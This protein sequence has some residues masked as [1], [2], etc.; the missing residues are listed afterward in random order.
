MAVIQH[1]EVHQRESIG[2]ATAPRNFNR[3]EAYK[4]ANAIPRL[5]ASSCE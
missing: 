2:V 1:R 3:K 5:I 4:Q